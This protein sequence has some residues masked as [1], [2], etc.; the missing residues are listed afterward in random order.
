[1]LCAPDARLY[2]ELRFHARF[3]AAA[4]TADGEKKALYEGQTVLVQGVMDAVLITPSGE[5]WLVDYKTDRL[6]AAEKRN[7][8]LAEEKLRTRH[9][10]QLSYYAAACRDI[11]GRTPDRTL[12]YSLAL[13]DTV[14]LP[15]SLPDG[16]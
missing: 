2:R 9:A 5:L 6:S 7:R 11:F 10:L 4:F 14:E 8:A 1:M 12:I 13:G 16:V 15:L 3:P